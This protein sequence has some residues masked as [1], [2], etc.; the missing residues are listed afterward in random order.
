MKS[1]NSHSLIVWQCL[2]GYNLE[3]ELNLNLS[4]FTFSA[5]TVKSLNHFKILCMDL[6]QN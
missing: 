5:K 4:Y 6:K 2:V 1:L 3:F